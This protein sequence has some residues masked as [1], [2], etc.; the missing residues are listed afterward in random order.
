MGD[1][2]RTISWPGACALE[3]R[4]LLRREWLV[5]NGFGGYASGT[6]V[7]VATRRYHSLLISALPHPL[8]RWMMLNHLFETLRLPDGITVHIGYRLLSGDGPVILEI[9]PSVNFRSHNVMVSKPP[10]APYALSIRGDR[11]EISEPKMPNLPPL[12]MFLYGEKATFTSDGGSTQE[13]FY[14][15]EAD[16]GYDSRGTLWSPGYFTT[17]LLPE[18]DATLVASD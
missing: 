17:D 12:R 9:R 18:K 13:L 6:V 14:R 8:G 3:A 1:L 10:E 15:R 7:G 16:R 5:T 4:Q 11:Y 2:I